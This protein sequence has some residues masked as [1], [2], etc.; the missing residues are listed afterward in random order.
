MLISLGNNQ[1]LSIFFRH[2]HIDPETGKEYYKRYT[3]CVIRLGIG[4]DAITLCE[5]DTKVHKGDI[6]NK[7]LGRLLSLQRAIDCVNN[8]P[9]SPLLLDKD[10]RRSIWAEYSK[11]CKTCGFEGGQVKKRKKVKEERVAILHNS[12]DF[13]L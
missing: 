7:C 5:A 3:R 10:M 2:H 11:T 13:T 12:P 1:K 4:E 9:T 8:D 6:Y